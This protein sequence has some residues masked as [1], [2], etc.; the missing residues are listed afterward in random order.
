MHQHE[1]IATDVT[2]P[3]ERNCQGK[4]NGDRCVNGIAAAAQYVRAD[5]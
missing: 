1:A 5:F 3:R 2:R 4:A